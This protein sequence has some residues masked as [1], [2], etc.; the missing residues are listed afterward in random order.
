MRNFYAT[1][2]YCQNCYQIQAYNSKSFLDAQPMLRILHWSWYKV[3]NEN[4]QI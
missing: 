4:Q 1:V 3:D 2:N